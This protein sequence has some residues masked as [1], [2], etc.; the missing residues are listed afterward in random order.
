MR[1]RQDKEE[2]EEEEKMQKMLKDKDRAQD[3]VHEEKIYSA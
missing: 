3:K 1:E 2:K